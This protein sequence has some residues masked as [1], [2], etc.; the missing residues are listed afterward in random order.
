MEDTSFAIHPDHSHPSETVSLTDIGSVQQHVWSKNILKVVCEK[1]HVALRFYREDILR[2]IMNPQVEPSFETSAALVKS[3]E[4]VEV[5]YEES[6]DQLTLKTKQLFIRIVKSPMRISVYDKEGRTLTDEGEKG[7]AHDEKGR[8]FG[9]KKMEN[10]DHFY[11]FGEKTGFLDKKGEKLSMWNTDV[12]APHNPETKELYVSIPFFIVL[13]EGRTHGMFLDNTY[14]STFDF[15]SSRDTYSFSAAG[16]QLDYYVLAGPSPKH[17]LEQY[18]V[19]TGR[20]PMPPKWSLGYHQSRYSYGSEQEVRILVD[21]FHDKQIPL[22]AVHLDIHYMD[23]YRNFTFDDERFPDPARLIGDLKARGIQV[24]PIVDTGIKAADYDDVYKEGCD[25][26]LFCTYQD[27]QLFYGEVWPGNSVFPD[28]TKLMTRNWWGEKHQF[29]TNLGIEGIWNDMNEP[30]VFNETKTMDLEVV[31]ENDGH[32]KT[33]RELHNV[34]GMLMEQSTYEG[35]KKLL[36]GKRP[37]ILTRAGYAGIQ[38]YGA[39]WTGDN[40]SFWEHLAM[41]LPM[42]IN[43]GLSGVAFCGSDVGGFAHDCSG[44]LLTRWTQVGAFLP[45]FR[46]HS[47]LD[48]AR[49][50]PWAFGEPYESIIKKYIRLRYRWLPYIYG[51]F[52]E[53]HETGAPVIRPLFMEFPNDRE[54]YQLSDQFLIG[55]NVLI[56]PI[57][58]PGTT[59]RAVYLPKGTW[60]DYW[61]DERLDGGRY[62]LANA[63][64]DRIP[65]FV[66]AGT[67]LPLGEERL[68]TKDSFNQL[69]IHLYAD[70]ESFGGTIYDDDGETFGYNSGDTFTREVGCEIQGESLSIFTDDMGSFK[71]DWKK[72]LYVVHGMKSFTQVW[73]NNRKLQDNVIISN[74]NGSTLVEI[75]IEH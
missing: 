56:A 9:H 8:V 53:A 27:G 11:G 18:T 46:N 35:M 28:F 1:G 29:Y 61:S 16:G 30:A 51:L 45:Y 44:E 40:R 39:I 57:T 3:A 69:T 54:T 73:F 60:Y 68:S 21:L 10:T 7:M 75:E 24:V 17:V 12:Y 65:I 59:H 58:A 19:L 37:F 70:K 52:K 64:L 23:S 33:H 38:R 25:K 34:Y 41:T 48:F 74:R 49:Q 26:D 66:K 31:H 5:S 32:P 2:I 13:S 67:V 36:G 15:Q 72:T 6:G 62:V 43:L 55:A 63:S 4:D 14:K 42:C 20:M 22:D 71:P 47:A 50:E